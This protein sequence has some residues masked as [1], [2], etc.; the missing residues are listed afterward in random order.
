MTLE[1]AP[2]AIEHVR[3]GVTAVALADDP[4]RGV[5]HLRIDDGIEHP[6]GP[7]PHIRRID[8]ALLFQLV[9]FAVVDI[10]TDVFLA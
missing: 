4:L 7:D 1:Q 2:Q 8:H 3:I 5:K 9:G 10:I 6:I